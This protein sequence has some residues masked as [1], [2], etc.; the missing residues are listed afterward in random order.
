ML[1]GK[2]QVSGDDLGIVQRHF[3]VD[4]APAE[5]HLDTIEADSLRQRQRF[6]VRSELQV[7]VGDADRQCAAGPTRQ[8]PAQ[9][10][11]RHGSDQPAARH[12]CHAGLHYHFS[13]RL[14]SHFSV[15]AII[16]SQVTTPPR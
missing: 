14:A 8:T 10:G 15:E 6:R 1:A 13:F 7:P 11:K 12:I 3:I 4:N 9:S 2:A 16:S 5:R